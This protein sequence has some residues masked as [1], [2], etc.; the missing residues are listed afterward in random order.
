MTTVPA[1]KKYVL[2]SLLIL[3]GCQ[4]VLLQTT[5]DREDEGEVFVYL[6]PF[7]REA[8]RLRFSLSAFAALRDDG[9]EIPVPLSLNEFNAAD[10]TRQRL[11]AAARLPSGKY[12]GF[13]VSV[14][15]AALKIE[16]GAVALLVPETPQ[17]MA[18]PFTVEKRKAMVITLTL[19]YAQSLQ[20]EVNFSPAFLMA[21]PARPLVEVTGYA[22]NAGDDAITVFDKIHLQ[23]TSVIATGSGPRSIALDQRL[24]RA[25]VVLSGDDAVEVFDMS[26][27]NLLAKTMLMRGD[28]PQELALT[29]DGLSLLVVNGR[30]DTVSII[31]TIALVEV[32]RIPVGRSPRSLVI[33]RTGRRAFVF[34]SLSD[35]IS[36]IDIPYRQVM[37]TITTGP[38]PLRGQFNRAGDRLYVIHAA[39]PYLFV[40]D[41]SSF[42]VVRREFIGMGTISLKVDTRT[43]QL[44][45][46]K[47]ND[48]M[49]TVYDPLSFA[50][51]G[52]IPTG[53]AVAFMTIDGET[54]YLYLLIPERKVLMIVNLASKRPVSEVDVSE[55]P[56]WVTMMGER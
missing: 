29:P 15:S 33:D 10:M 46:G 27:E 53:G 36:V 8:E 4:T 35:S 17:K 49:V 20:G 14:K 34:N 55:R 52:S 28:D 9:T 2:I 39:Y 18:F 50:P 23:A 44:Y 40:I 16:G 41:P 26:S 7:S 21:I 51:V 43:D 54:N 24:K 22:S 5:P 6:Q 3:C 47:K 13:L 45:I 25:Y 56:V 12:G 37:G 19:R 42:S 1:I 30:S 32:S 11:I 31:D 48:P 38:E